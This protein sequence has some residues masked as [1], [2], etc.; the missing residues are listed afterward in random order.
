MIN[1]V[2]K[3]ERN[4]N[5]QISFQF[6]SSNCQKDNNTYVGVADQ[7]KKLGKQVISKK[8]KKPP[9]LVGHRFD[10]PS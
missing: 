2:S 8:F 10:R 5:F 3:K 9:G 1:Q 7:I 6:F 4:P